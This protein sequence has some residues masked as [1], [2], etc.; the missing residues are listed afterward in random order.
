MVCLFNPQKRTI[1]KNR[2]GLNRSP[3]SKKHTM[4][5]VWVGLRKE[6]W[7]VCSTR[8]KEQSRKSD[9]GLIAARHRINIPCLG[10]GQVSGRNMGCLFNPEK[11]TIPKTDQGLIVARHRRNI[12]CLG[13]GLG[14]GRNMGCLFNPEKRTIPKTDQGLIA[15][16]YRRNNPCLG[17][18]QGGKMARGNQFGSI[19]TFQDAF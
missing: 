2:S 10:C 14:S 15:A 13:C 4:F 19:T 16:R 3:A 18:G 9:Q 6:T 5:G 17:N 7:Y 8:R 1:P 11:R 12:P